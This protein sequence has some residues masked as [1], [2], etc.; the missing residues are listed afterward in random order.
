MGKTTDCEQN[1]H[2]KKGEYKIDLIAICSTRLISER[3]AL[4]RDQ[5]VIAITLEYSLSL[6][7]RIAELE[8]SQ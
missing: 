6:K 2:Y 5:L 7:T 8:R 3:Y 4:R 1:I